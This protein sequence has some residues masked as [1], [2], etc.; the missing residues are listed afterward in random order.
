M[1]D[2]EAQEPVTHGC[3]NVTRYKPILGER[4]DANTATSKMGKEPFYRVANFTAIVEVECERMPAPRHTAE[5]YYNE[6][7][8]ALEPDKVPAMGRLEAWFNAKMEEERKKPP[9]ARLTPSK[10]M[11]A[12]QALKA[13]MTDDQ[14]YLANASRAGGGS[15]LPECPTTDVITSYDKCVQLVT[16]RNQ[17]WHLK[18]KA[19]SKELNGEFSTSPAG[20]SINKKDGRLLWNKN[21]EGRATEFEEWQPICQKAWMF[22]PDLNK[23]HPD[24]VAERSSQELELKCTQCP[25]DETASESCRHKRAEPGPWNG[26]CEV[27]YFPVVTQ[28]G[29]AAFLQL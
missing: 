18:Y 23:A 26:P 21:P 3:R 15:S 4:S 20:C 22:G 25:A 19:D 7:Q 5:Y 29:S 8:K 6:Q 13:Q 17:T 28:L 11:S 16:E 27:G 9:A 24:Y 2:T 12:S 14:Y 10:G 1:S